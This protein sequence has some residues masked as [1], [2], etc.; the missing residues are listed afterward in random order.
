VE[1]QRLPD[2]GPTKRD[3][4]KAVLRGACGIAPFVGQA[5]AEIIDYVIPDQRIER[6]ET[7]FC[8]LADRLKKLEE[9]ELSL[10]LRDP[11]RIDLLEDGWRQ[12]ARA[13]SNERQQQIATLVADSIADE[14]CD[15]LESKRVLRLLGEVDDPEIIVLAGYLPENQ[16]NDYRDRHAHVLRA[17]IRGYGRPAIASPQREKDR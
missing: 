4:T 1:R 16:M 13:L 14:A 9:G 8:C 12:A 6:V 10:R 17:P 2:L 15:Y 3:I 7:Y 11:E 5:L